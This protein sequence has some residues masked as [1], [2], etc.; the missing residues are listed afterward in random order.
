M[1]LKRCNLFD[2][3]RVL[4]GVLLEL[5]CLLL[6]ELCLLLHLLRLALDGLSYCK[7]GEGREEDGGW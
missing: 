6:V 3:L 1:R 2:V 5:L 7:A 4:A